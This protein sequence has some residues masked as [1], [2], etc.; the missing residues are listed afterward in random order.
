MIGFLKNWHSCRENTITQDV[1]KYVHVISKNGCLDWIACR[2]ALANS[3]I[4][5]GCPRVMK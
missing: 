5:P 4:V 1:Q 2:K 3:T